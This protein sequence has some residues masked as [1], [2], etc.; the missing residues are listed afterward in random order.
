[1]SSWMPFLAIT[2]TIV[3]FG[4]NFVPLKGIEVHNHAFFQWV[5]CNAILLTAFPY[6]LYKMDS[7]TF[8]PFA[9]IGG[10]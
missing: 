8:E 1:M 6:Y 4:S 3:G 5:M 2:I 7:I 10:K 9:S